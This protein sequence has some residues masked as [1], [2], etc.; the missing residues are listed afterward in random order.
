MEILNRRAKHDYYIDEVLEAGI[1]LTGT[2]IKSIRQGSA[3]IKDSYAI[4]RNNEVILLNMFVAEYREGNIF[5]HKETRDRKLL[6]HKNEIKKL[7]KY[8]EKGNYT[9][10]PLKLYFK[11]NILKVELG[12][13]RGK[14]EYQKKETIKERDIQRDIKKQI[15]KY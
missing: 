1:V 6:L 3:N 10:V 15:S 13:C 7:I 14:K 12:V 8:K 5:N 2:E 11:K 9:F 4:I